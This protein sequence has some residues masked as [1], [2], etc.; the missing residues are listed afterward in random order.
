M[1]MV[2]FF[3]LLRNI[4]FP[5]A[6]FHIYIFNNWTI[7]RNT[8]THITKITY[9]IIRLLTKKIIRSLWLNFNQ[10]EVER[11]FCV[12]KFHPLQDHS[13]IIVQSQNVFTRSLNVFTRSLKDK[14]MKLDHFQS[15]ISIF[16]IKQKTSI[17]EVDLFQFV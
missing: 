10:I 16:F 13:K 1:V 11:V 9:W 6:T 17:L 8:H 4:Y 15:I 3:L 2:N 5:T 12:Q 14:L 7:Q